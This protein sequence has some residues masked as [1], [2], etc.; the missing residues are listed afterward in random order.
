MRRRGKV[1][2][3]C[4]M[5]PTVPTVPGMKQ[6]TGSLIQN[7]VSLI[8]PSIPASTN[9]NTFQS[10]TAH[11]TVHIHVRCLVCTTF[12]FL[13][14]VEKKPTHFFA[15]GFHLTVDESLCVTLCQIELL[16]PPSNQESRGGKGQSKDRDAN[17]GPEGPG[18]RVPFQARLGRWAGRTIAPPLIGYVRFL[19]H[20]VWHFIHETSGYR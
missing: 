12:S 14:F 3:P 18:R 1:F 15:Q 6:P 8:Q 13:Y 10:H 7:T 4:P 11:C 9:L 5:L 16:L 17:K 2:S 19:S 20:T